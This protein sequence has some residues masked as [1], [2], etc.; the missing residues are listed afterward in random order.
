MADHLAIPQDPDGELRPSIGRHGMLLRLAS[1]PFWS[2]FTCTF[3]QQVA[4]SRH[5]T[6]NAGRPFETESRS[7]S[8]GRQTEA[9][10]RSVRAGSDLTTGIKIFVDISKD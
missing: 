2:I 6:F 1:F 5:S 3:W 10:T 8:R 7:R 9:L 4:T